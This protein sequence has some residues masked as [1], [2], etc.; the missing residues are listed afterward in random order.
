MARRWST[1][2]KRSPSF[3]EHININILQH[4]TTICNSLQHSTTLYKDLQQFTTIYNKT[5]SSVHVD[6]QI[7]TFQT[8]RT[9]RTSATM[10]KRLYVIPECLHRYDLPSPQPCHKARTTGV[11]CMQPPGDY[12]RVELTN[13]PPKFCA[14]C[15]RLDQEKEAARRAKIRQRPVTNPNR[16]KCDRCVRHTRVCNKS[17]PTCGECEM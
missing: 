6:Q 17:R 3:V 2:R 7:I 4:P 8:Q 15:K 5:V 14:D 13:K 9:L 11:N 16:L 12:P 1:N 10:C